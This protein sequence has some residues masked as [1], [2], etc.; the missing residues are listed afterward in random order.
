MF[1]CHSRIE[2]DWGWAGG[3]RGLCFVQPPPHPGEPAQGLERD[4]GFSLWA[5]TF[6]FLNVCVCVCMRL[7]VS[8]CMCVCVSVCPCMFCVLQCQSSNSFE[9]CFQFTSMG[10]IWSR[11]PSLLEKAPRSDA[12]WKY[13]SA[14][15]PLGSR[16]PD[17]PRPATRGR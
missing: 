9:T 17:E 4:L 6:L 10:R 7:C 2:Q 16:A 5:H 14:G 15:R 11:S 12:Y 13:L 3:G 1:L 8:L